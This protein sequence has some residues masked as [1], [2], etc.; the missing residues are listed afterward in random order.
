MITREEMKQKI[1]A[2]NEAKFNKDLASTLDPSWVR[3]NCGKKN[4]PKPTL[5]Q[6]DGAPVNR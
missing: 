2:N 6:Y 1:A 5:D 3:V 4:G